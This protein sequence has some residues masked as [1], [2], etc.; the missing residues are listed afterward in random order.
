[1]QVDLVFH[2]PGAAPDGLLDFEETRDLEA[3]P[4]VGDNV[5]WTDT[6]ATESTEVERCREYVVRGVDWSMGS[7]TTGASVR[8]RLDFVAYG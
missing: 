5:L 1:M 7:D 8:V 2:H 3:L 6:V 4:R